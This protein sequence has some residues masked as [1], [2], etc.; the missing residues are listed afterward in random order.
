MKM[1]VN[2]NTGD[3]MAQFRELDSPGQRCRLAPAAACGKTA[4]AAKEISDRDA[5]SAHI[6]RFPPRQIVALHQKI[7]GQHCADEAAIENSARTQEV[8]REQLQRIFPILGLDKEHQD[9]RSDE[10]RQ[11]HPE[12]QVV[13]PFA[14]QAIAPGK[15]DSDQ[16]RAEKCERKKHA[17]GVDGEV[18]D[19][20]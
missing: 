7:A 12:A 6:S 5:R 11:Q 16:D 4:L 3:L 9:L 15:F 1:H 8:E 10:R 13:D 18:A 14:W 17:V 2:R 20:K 19:A